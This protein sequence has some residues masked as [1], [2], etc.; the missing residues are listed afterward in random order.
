MTTKFL[1][2][3]AACA[4]LASVVLARFEIMTR[5]TIQTGAKQENVVARLAAFL[6]EKF[7]LFAL[8][9]VAAVMLFLPQSAKAQ[10]AIPASVSTFITAIETLRDGWVLFAL[11]LA[12][13]TVSI[14]WLLMFRKGKK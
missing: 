4:A 2:L 3:K 8:L 7:S 10:A 13:A 1:N 5:S 6:V 9:L 11:L 12:S 14:S